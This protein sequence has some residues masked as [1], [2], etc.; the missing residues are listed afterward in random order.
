[1]P[2]SRKSNIALSRLKNRN[3]V[4]ASLPLLLLEYL[5]VG[6]AGGLV[7]FAFDPA[8][9]VVQPREFLRLSH[10]VGFSFPRLGRR[11]RTLSRPLA[12]GSYEVAFAGGLYAFGLPF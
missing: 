7:S 8:L 12:P 10:E 4:E 9:H 6:F 11:A 3:K 5:S 2:F 1:M